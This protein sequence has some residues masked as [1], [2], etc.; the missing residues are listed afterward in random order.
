MTLGR[1]MNTINIAGTSYTCPYSGMIPP[2]TTDEE[3][4]LRA[5]I[6]ANGVLVPVVVDEN[7]GVIDGENRLTIAADVGL[8]D[9]PVRVVSGLTADRK[10]EM[11]LDLNLHRRQLTRQQRHDII[12]RKL[13]A[14]PSRSNNS[15]ASE[16]GVSDKTVDAARERLESN[17]EIPKL[18][19]RRGRDGRTRSVKSPAVNE[20]TPNT[21]VAQN[22]RG[23]RRGPYSWWPDLEGIGR[24]AKRL[25]EDLHRLKKL[26]KSDRTLEPVQKIAGQFRQL[27]VWL[28]EMV[29]SADVGGEKV[30]KGV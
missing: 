14:D 3:R 6:L 17:S 1:L 2:L 18:A 21:P 28:E 4:E 10:F 7:Y 12:A 16:V 20:P 19:C 9:I 27:A 11:A 23:N 25:A 13:K 24:E 30:R 29:A 22:N 26:K 5:D 8:V 15:I